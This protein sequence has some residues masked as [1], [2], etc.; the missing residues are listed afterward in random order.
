MANMPR[1]AVVPRRERVLSDDELKA[2]WQ[3][4]EHLCWPFGS[5]LKLLILTGARREEIG[6][7]GKR[8]TGSQFVFSFNGTKHI[9][10]W[11]HAKSRLDELVEIPPWR[12]HDLSRTAAS[13]LQK[14]KTPLQ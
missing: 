10:A 4:A 13:G 6:Q 8:I 3:A 5:A 14:L 1:P 9:R 11:S 7:S 2:A 12:I